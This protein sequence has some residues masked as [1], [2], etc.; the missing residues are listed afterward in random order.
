MEQRN[1]GTSFNM[2]G[3]PDVVLGRMKPH[4]RHQRFTRDVVGVVRL[5]LMPENRQRDRG[6][7]GFLS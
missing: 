5:V 7:D 4:P 1:S 3:H 6:H 2:E